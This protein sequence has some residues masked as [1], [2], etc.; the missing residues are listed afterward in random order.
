[1]SLPSIITAIKTMAYDTQEIRESLADF[2]DDPADIKDEEIMA[3]IEDWAYE[4]L[5]RGYVLVDEYG[6]ELDF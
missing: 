2:Y 5:G 1:M 4:D 3:M 6:D